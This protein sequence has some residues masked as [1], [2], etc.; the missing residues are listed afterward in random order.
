M[1]FSYKCTTHAEEYTHRVR[2]KEKN[3]RMDRAKEIE[4]S[5]ARSRHIYTSFHFLDQ[6]ISLYTDRFT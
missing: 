1:L 2:G 4:N 5:N 6:M 3:Q